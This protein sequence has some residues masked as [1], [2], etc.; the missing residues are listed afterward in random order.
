VVLNVGT[1]HV[2]E[3]GGRAAIAQAKGELVEALPEHGCAVLN[4]DDPLVW[5]MRSRTVASVL[6]FAVDAAPDGPGVW[7]EQLRSDR[8]GRYRFDVFSRS[9]DGSEDQVEVELQLVGRHQVGNAVAATAAAVALGVPLA[10]CAAALTAATPRS[11]WRMEVADRADG[12]TVIND[13][14]NANPDSMRAALA[15]LAEL[16]R[17]GRTTWAVLGD[18]LELGPDS[19]A[20]H[21]K[22]G[23]R[24]AELGISRLVVIGA[25]A[26]DLAAG[27]RA[28]GLDAT[29][30]AD[31]SEALA[32]VLDGLGPGAVVL[33]K[34]SRGL[35]LNT[36]S[37]QILQAGVPQ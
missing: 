7:A 16:G 25:Y 20:E 3:F 8:A 36:V 31:R 19:A 2:G 4:A 6:A 23:R 37:E 14:Y 33:V 1:A 12:V 11:R 35:A 29:I 9:L 22:I 17:D 13:A 32:A 26:A 27:A 5:A 10:T 18:M 15:T 34:A 24:A 30:V 28:S 21:E